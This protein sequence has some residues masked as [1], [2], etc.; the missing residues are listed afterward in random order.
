MTADVTF[1]WLAVLAFSHSCVAYRQGRY[2]AG[3]R[4]FFL[5]WSAAIICCVAL[6]RRLGVV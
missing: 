3:D 4:L 6:L 5:A 1:F 2:V